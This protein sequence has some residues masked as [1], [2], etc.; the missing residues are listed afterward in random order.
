[1]LLLGV[2]LCPRLKAQE[3]EHVCFPDS[4]PAYSLWPLSTVWKLKKNFKEQGNCHHI[5]VVSGRCT[6][7]GLPAEEKQEKHWPQSPAPSNSLY[8]QEKQ[9]LLHLIFFF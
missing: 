9:F 5:S 1:M 4:F 2:R 3:H 7:K 8:K 6:L